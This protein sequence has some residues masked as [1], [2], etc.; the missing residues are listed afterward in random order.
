MGIVGDGSNND[1]PDARI[2]L[3]VCSPDALPAPVAVTLHRAAA[4]SVGGGPARYAGRVEPAAVSW[5]VDW[6]YEGLVAPAGVE[7]HYT[8][9]E[10]EG[11]NESALQLYH[12]VV[13][14]GISRF[15]PLPAGTGPEMQ[16]NR[17]Q[18]LVP[19]GPGERRLRLALGTSDSAIFY[20]GFE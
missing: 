6:G 16:R 20:D 17:L 4:T 9:A 2:S 18:A 11:L 13:V 10:I 5:E 3:A 14:N 15:V 1:S 8:D 7:V 12:E 19:F